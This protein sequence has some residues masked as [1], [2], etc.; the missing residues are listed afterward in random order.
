MKTTIWTWAYSYHFDPLDEMNGISDSS[1]LFHYVSSKLMRALYFAYKSCVLGS[2]NSGSRTKAIVAPFSRENIDSRF[3]FIVDL[4]IPHSIVGRRGLYVEKFLHHQSYSFE[5]LK[6]LL[7]SIPQDVSVVLQGNPALHENL[8]FF[9]DTWENFVA[10]QRAFAARN[11]IEFWD[12]SKIIRDYQ[13][14]LS[15]ALNSTTGWKFFP[16]RDR[17]H[18]AMLGRTIQPIVDIL[19]YMAI[20]REMRRNL[21]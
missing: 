12:T 15:V 14:A 3:E 1:V 18:D 4:S 11:Q 16:H 5:N 13:I 10:E 21:L 17:S 6:Q 2:L 20:V 7:R 19:P 8:A 9:Q